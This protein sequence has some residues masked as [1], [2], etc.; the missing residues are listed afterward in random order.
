MLRGVAII[1]PLRG[2]GIGET[3]CCCLPLFL[4]P[5]PCTPDEAGLSSDSSPSDDDEN[6]DI[7][8]GCSAMGDSGGGG[9]K[10]GSSMAAAAAA[11]EADEGVSAGVC[12][13]IASKQK[14]QGQK[15]G[16]T[17]APTSPPVNNSLHAQYIRQRQ[18]PRSKTGAA[19]PPLRKKNARRT[20][21]VLKEKEKMLLGVGSPLRRHP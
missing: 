8:G 14:R 16:R 15:N 6:D 20:N 13:A 12:V 1:D 9:E 17:N 21:F 4:P 2:T 3:T 18:P 10:G 19:A 11:A 5:L 7:K